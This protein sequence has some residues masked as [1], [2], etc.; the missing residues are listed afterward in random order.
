[1]TM[2]EKIISWLKAKINSRFEDS[3]NVQRFFRAEYGR[4]AE[5]AYRHWQDKREFYTKYN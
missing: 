2:V 1:M 4:D 5:I 3:D